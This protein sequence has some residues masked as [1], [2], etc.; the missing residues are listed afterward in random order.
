MLANAD[1]ALIIGDAALR[2]AI[3]AET[4]G[5]KLGPDGEW[6]AIAA[7]LNS[8]V[9]AQYIAPA[10]RLREATSAVSAG[11][12]L[13]I[14]DIVKEWRHLTELPAVL[15]V[16]AARTNS[17]PNQRIPADVVADFQA[18]RDFGVTQIP[19][20]A[21]EAANEMHLPENE[22]RLYLEEN[23]DY[24]LDPE[25]LK[26]LQRFF[27]ESHSRGLIGP[28]QPINIAGKIAIPA[29]HLP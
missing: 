24:S 29:T 17:F 19:Q 23:I 9:A 5:V 20:I 13:H 21:A 22:L 27:H 14:Y 7:S 26:G 11:T 10:E 16:W 1:A 25:N 2:I 15:A 8:L 4:H 12:L 3:A 28:L 18:S 6:L